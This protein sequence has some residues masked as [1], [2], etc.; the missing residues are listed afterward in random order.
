M[1]TEIFKGT[2][3]S[4]YGSPLD[5]ALSFNGSYEAYTSLDEVKSGNDFPN[6][7]ELVTFVNNKRKANARQKE[8]QIALDAAG[9][10]KPTL[11]DPQVQLKGM[12]K[13]LVAAG[14]SEAEATQIAQ[15]TLGVTLGA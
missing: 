2:I 4:A 1:K 6:N 14:R 5:K 13:I 3:E 7:D 9:I 15:T 10:V 8:M 11:D 12:I